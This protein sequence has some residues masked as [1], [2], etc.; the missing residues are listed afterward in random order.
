MN[1]QYNDNTPTPRLIFCSFIKPWYLDTWLE[2][3][4]ACSTWGSVKSI[5]LKTSINGIIQQPNNIQLK[6][7]DKQRKDLIP[8]GIVVIAPT[9]RAALGSA[10]FIE[11]AEN[12]LT[13]RNF[14]LKLVFN[15]QRLN[16]TKWKWWN[17]K[18]LRIR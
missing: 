3:C 5:A 18:L 13:C 10:R 1:S 7:I 16:G 15:G 6:P 8:T 11:V 2:N 17:W 12:T 14:F 9:I 4:D